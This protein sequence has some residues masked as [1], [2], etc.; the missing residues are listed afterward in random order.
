M[1]SFDVYIR[2]FFRIGKKTNEQVSHWMGCIWFYIAAAK[3]FPETSTFFLSLPT[4]SGTTCDDPAYNIDDFDCECEQTLMLENRARAVR[5]LRSL[6][7]GMS[8]LAGL[9]SELIPEETDEVRALYRAAF[10]HN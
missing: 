2:L 8:S 1:P 4:C 7:W 3:D 9:G 10:E 5:Y 6:G